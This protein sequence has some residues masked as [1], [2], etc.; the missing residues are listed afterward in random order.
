MEASY[1]WP[2]SMMAITINKSKRHGDKNIMVSIKNTKL[3]VEVFKEHHVVDDGDTF[4]ASS[5]G[6]TSK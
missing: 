1:N 2:S 4:V 6:E 5:E 3:M